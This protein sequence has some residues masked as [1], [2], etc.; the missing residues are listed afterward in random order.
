MKRI[1]ALASFLVLV[2]A[3]SNE[4]APNT[5]PSSNAPAA[6]KSAAP[7]EADMT[8]KEKAIWET[9][10]KKDYVAFGDSLASDFIE[11]ADNGVSDKAAVVAEIKDFVPTE[12]TFSAWKML[13]IDDDA[14]ILTYDV[15]IKGTFKGQDLPPGTFHTVSV[16]A[17]RDGKWQAVLYQ[18]TL[19]KTSPPPPV[20]ATATTKP[21]KAA[22]APAK[23]AETG[24]DAIAN[25]K[26]VWDLFRS[27]NTE[28]FGA[29][30]DPG[31]LE[32][33]GDGVYDK[34]AAIKAAEFDV[35]QFALSEWKAAKIDDDAAIVTYLVKSSDPKMES[36]RHTTVWAN[37]GG[38][39]MAMLH[40]GTTVAKAPAAKPAK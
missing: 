36:Q 4:P 21:E 38:K 5:A 18:Q 13:P 22:P 24:P 29:L 28:G 34:A 25:E 19:A 35:S 2:A 17:N 23:P 31:F 30:L 14:V 8:A 26:I 1:L 37:R 11:V 10:K 39:W 33:E 40:I 6:T 3:C 15:N 7:T 16:W 20:P 27:R 9:L 12:V 32:I